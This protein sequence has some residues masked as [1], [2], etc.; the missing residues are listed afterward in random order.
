MLTR[1]LWSSSGMPPGTIGIPV[2]AAPCV[3]ERKSAYAQCKSWLLHAGV[4]PGTRLS[5]RALA[6]QFGCSR[7]PLREGLLRLEQE[8]LVER[9][10]GNGWFVSVLSER[11][12]RDIFACRAELE[13]LA[14]S[15]AIERASDMEVEQL[16]DFLESAERAHAVDDIASMTAA[17]VQFHT[18]V[19]RMTHSD[20]VLTTMEPLRAH[21][22]RIRHLISRHR[23]RH[24][25]A[26]EHRAVF[27]A[28]QARDSD[29]A[30]KVIR[31][32]VD[33]DLQVVI[34]HL[35]ALAPPRLKS[36]PSPGGV[37]R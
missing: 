16:R 29:R 13:V 33:L 19:Y 10:P 20:W 24:V 8:R 3:A 22:I 18:A 1:P 4:A 37:V 5:E 31:Q 14:V 30:K 11:D 28:L 17:N 27:E 15:L 9:S 7:T 6:K 35:A 32:H 2:A 21:G 36:S 23:T 25:Y 26:E 12:V 34:R